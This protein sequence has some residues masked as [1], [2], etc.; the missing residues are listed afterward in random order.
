M[1]NL[2][3]L[4]ELIERTKNCGNR[5]HLIESLIENATKELIKESRNRR[6]DLLEVRDQ[7]N[8][9]INAAF[10]LDIKR[11]GRH[12][13]KAFVAEVT[14]THCDPPQEL[15]GNCKLFATSESEAVRQLHEQGYKVVSIVSLPERTDQ[16]TD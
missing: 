3:I 7:L 14:A 6:L 11:N 12:S 10:D 13:V 16:C 1:T 8:A 5:S 9:V 15:K 2:T 4:A